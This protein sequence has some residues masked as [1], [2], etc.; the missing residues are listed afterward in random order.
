M[1]RM[2]TT[3]AERLRDGGFINFSSGFPSINVQKPASAGD[4]RW[5]WRCSFWLCE[6]AFRSWLTLRE[7]GQV[8]LLGETPNDLARARLWQTA[9]ETVN[10]IL[11]SQRF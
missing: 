3:F 11:A 9:T 2:V 10:T 1:L 6:R 7:E 5:F 4:E 8:E